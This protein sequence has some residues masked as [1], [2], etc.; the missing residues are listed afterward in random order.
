MRPHSPQDRTQLAVNQ[1]KLFDAGVKIDS[2]F[3][4]NE[5]VS[6]P[7]VL[8]AQLQLA[9]YNG[10]IN[11][12]IYRSYAS[13]YFH[14]YAKKARELTKQKEM[15]QLTSSIPCNLLEN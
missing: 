15:V 8:E 4:V 11:H 12:D 6:S 5:I 7:C 3:F 1:L 13:T 9:T 10:I 14:H 2:I